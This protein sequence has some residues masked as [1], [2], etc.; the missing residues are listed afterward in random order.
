MCSG[1][2]RI[3]PGGVR[4]DSFNELFVSDL[5]DGAWKAGPEI[6]HYAAAARWLW[7]GKKRSLLL[8]QEQHTRQYPA[9]PL[10]P[11]PLLVKTIEQNRCVG[12]DVLAERSVAGYIAAIASSDGT[13]HVL[14][15]EPTSATD[16]VMEYRRGKYAV[17]P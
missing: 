3:D 16:A 10:G 5:L 6:S 13:M 7:G 17:S 4:N 12:T 11:V 2:E 14:Y 8:L 15:V 1:Y 9:P